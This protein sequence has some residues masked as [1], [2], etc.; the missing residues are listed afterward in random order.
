MNAHN[1][2]PPNMECAH[3]GRGE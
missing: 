3:R 1:C 2:V